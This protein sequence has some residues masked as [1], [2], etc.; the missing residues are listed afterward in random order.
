MPREHATCSASRTPQKIQ[1]RI[2]DHYVEDATDIPVRGTLEREPLLHD[3][4][5]S[6]SS[7]DSNLRPT[8]LAALRTIRSQRSHV[9][10][11]VFGDDHVGCLSDSIVGCK[12]SSILTDKL[13]KHSDQD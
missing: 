4:D 6:I 11:D 8:R 12:A 5:T 13:G 7:P 3:K 2:S 1:N 9:H 10:V